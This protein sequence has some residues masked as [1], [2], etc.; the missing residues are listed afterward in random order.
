MKFLPLCWGTRIH[1]EPCPVSVKEERDD[2]V[3]Q[4]AEL[5][6]K[7]DAFMVGYAEKKARGEKLRTQYNAVVAEHNACEVQ[8]QAYKAQLEAV[9]LELHTVKAER[10][11]LNGHVDELRNKTKVGAETL[12]VLMKEQDD[13]KAFVEEFTGHIHHMTATI[14]MLNAEN[15]KLNTECNILHGRLLLAQKSM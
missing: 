4:C 12:A 5:K 13:C 11:V 3:A 1:P 9:I 14:D 2:A 8:C 10:D 7:H 15:E 6:A